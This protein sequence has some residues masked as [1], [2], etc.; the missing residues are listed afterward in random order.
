MGI[1]KFRT[2][3]RVEVEPRPPGDFGFMYMSG[4]KQSE[5]DYESDCEQ[6]A[7]E[8]RR[9]VD[10]G[11]LPSLDRQRGVHVRC[12]VERVCEHCGSDWTETSETYNGGCCS[13]DD[14]NMPEYDAAE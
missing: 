10:P 11:L 7:K 2:N 12:D 1:K 9:H 6:I 3:F 4:Q 5:A 13:G 14:E 8:I